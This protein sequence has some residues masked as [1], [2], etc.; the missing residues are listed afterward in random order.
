MSRSSAPEGPSRSVAGGASDP[1]TAPGTDRGQV[2]P[3]PALVALAVVGLALSLYAGALSDL[4]DPGDDE[5]ATA[6]VALGAV[7]ER[8]CEGGAVDPSRLD[9]G[10]AAAPDG[11]QVR[12]LLLAGD[13]R[14]TAG[15][16][17]PATAARATRTV[18][19]RLGPTTTVPGRLAVVVW[20]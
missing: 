2:D 8:V 10:L 18:A 14:W 1:D 20:E 17:P 6:A 19:V 9:E 13:R 4:P 3:L 15:P 11:R 5:D 7:C 12:I 16:E